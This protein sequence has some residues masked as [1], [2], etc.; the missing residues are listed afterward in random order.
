VF[1]IHKGSRPSGLARTTHCAHPDL[2]SRPAEA[3]PKSPGRR[4]LRI[5]IGLGLLGLPIWF[6]TPG[7]WTI[8]S[9][10]A[11]VNAELITLTSPIEGLV[12]QAPPSAGEFVTQGSVLV[13]VL[14]PQDHDKHLDELNSEAATVLARVVALKEHR[15]RA[16]SLKHELANGFRKYKDSM[17]QRL[18]HELAEAR[19]EAEAAE[20]R[21][22]QRESEEREEL[23]IA[24]RSM[25]S[26]RELNEARITT[27]VARRNLERSRT[28]VARLSDQLESMKDG[29]FTGPG[30]SRNDVPYS[31]Q[32]IDDLTVQ[33]LDDEERIQ[34]EEAR[35]AQLQRRI[36]TESSRVR[37]QSSYQLKAPSD[38]II[39]RSYVT[40]DSSVAPQTSL[41]Q[42]LI[43]SSSFVDAS[44]PEK[45]ADEIRPGD[46]VTIRLMGSSVEV[47][48]TVKYL[49]SEDARV[50]DDTLAARTPELSRNEVH[51]I[52]DPCGGF[53]R[54][55]EFN[56]YFVG[57]R[58]AV[59]F[60]GI[61]RSVLHAR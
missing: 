36:Q 25:S 16:E 21:L 6:L 17:V 11:I 40:R 19:S 24:R 34:E 58:A 38:G 56:Q 53:S 39:W 15:S 3:P 30:D 2:H 42:I 4:V 47:P 1:F 9:S 46:K 52:I 28:A 41:V 61:T 50:K 12:T 13:Q 59:C 32:K 48:G 35:L 55:P 5:L 37:Q 8:S 27:E 20:A 51:V 44:L 10:Q 26:Q 43:A 49:I 60:P 33:Q 18:T 29:V 54:D 14:A 31:R 7:L 22:R 57:R 45:F 23:A